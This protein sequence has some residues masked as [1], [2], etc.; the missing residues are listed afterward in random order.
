MAVKKKSNVETKN[1][2]KSKHKLESTK[3]KVL[4]NQKKKDKRKQY[5]SDDVQKALDAVNKGLS[6]R[7]A[8]KKFGVPATSIHRALQHPKKL[9]SR[10]GPAPI[11][12][13]EV[14]KEII[15]WILYRAERDYPVS[16]T[17]LLDSVQAYIRRLKIQTPFTNDRPGR[18]WYENFRQRHQQIT[19]RTPQ[20]LTLIRAQVSEDDLRGWFEEVKAYLVKNN[21]LNIHPS[22][23]F[24]CDETNIQLIPKSEKILTR[25]GATTAYKVVHGY[26]KESITALFM[27]AADGTRAP[28]HD[29]NIIL[30]R[31]TT[32]LTIVIL[33]L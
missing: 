19:L 20:Q 29:K 8:A 1:S 21:L 14:E 33:C 10:H 6:Y 13:T 2:M 4:K 3:K 23:V 11:L 26:E 16:K 24:N 25:K 15:H 17:E 31:K 5:S 7:E 27:Y 18:H 9:N 12:S 32:V 30:T 28:P 22:R